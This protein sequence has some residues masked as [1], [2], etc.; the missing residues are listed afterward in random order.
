MI[1]YEGLHHVSL[2]V[3]D[4]KK[5]KDF[6]GR[7]LGLKEMERP[8]FDFPGAWYSLGGQQIHLIVHPASQTIRRSEKIDT[9]D[10]HVA[11]RIKDY[12]KTLAWLREQGV[13]V[14]EKPDSKSGF[15]QIFCCDPDGNI[16][17]LNVDRKD[18]IAKKKGQD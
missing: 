16:V 13:E 6:Y 14:L 11:L 4:L 3:S 5:A 9:K 8:P 17:E 10:G 18:Y 2:S 1:E 7:I 12:D 15:A